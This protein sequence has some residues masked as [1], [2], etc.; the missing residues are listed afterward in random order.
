MPSE[1]LLPVMAPQALRGWLTQAGVFT[2]R[3]A[4][5]AIFV[6]Y[7]L[8]WITIGDGL[9]WHSLAVLATWGMTLLIQRAE[10]RDT[11]AL[12]A[13]LDEL[14][15]VHGDAQD[16]LMNVDDKDAEEVEREREMVRHDSPQAQARRA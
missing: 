13:K 2:S 7:G 15:K 10:H 6:V 16:E 8:L 1:P 4:A 11:Q 12:H 3:P 9:K 5:F 14:L